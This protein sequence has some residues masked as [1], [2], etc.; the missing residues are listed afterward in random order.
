M[1]YEACK[2]PEHIWVAASRDPAMTTH[3]NRISH[4]V[5]FVLLGQSSD[6]RPV[7]HP[8]KIN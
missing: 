3:V 7:A 5:Q 2:I 6:V 4:G 1:A 8:H